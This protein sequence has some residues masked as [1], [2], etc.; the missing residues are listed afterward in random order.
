MKY[1]FKAILEECKNKNWLKTDITG[2]EIV[3]IRVLHTTEGITAWASW[4]TACVWTQIYIQDFGFRSN[5]SSSKK[6]I[7]LVLRFK[8]LPVTVVRA[9]SS[10]VWIYIWRREETHNVPCPGGNTAELSQVWKHSLT[11]TD[12]PHRYKTHFSPSLVCSVPSLR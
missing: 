2:E 8:H 11:L 3:W 7:G 1:Y 6:D 9:V 4:G 10:A 12:L 5:L